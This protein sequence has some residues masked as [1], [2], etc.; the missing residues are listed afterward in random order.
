MRI[1]FWGNFGIDNFGNECTLA[2]I[3]YNM[4]QRIPDAEFVCISVVPEDTARRHRIET[5]PMWSSESDESGSRLMQPIRR[6][7]KPVA[8]WARALRQA[9]GL[10]AVMVPGTGVLNDINEGSLGLPYNLFRWVL[11]TRSHG[12]RVFFVSVG[13]DSVTRLLPRLLIRCALGLARRCSFR[14]RQSLQRIRALGFQGAGEVFPDLAFSLPEYVPSTPLLPSRGKAVAVGIYN[15]RDQGRHGGVRQAYHDYVDQIS[16]LVLWLIEHRYTARLVIGDISG[17]M[18]VREDVRARLRARGFDLAHP[19]YTDEPATSYEQIMD[20]LASVDFVIAS[21]FHN[22]VLALFLG[23]PVISLSYEAKIDAVMLDMGLGEYC[24]PLDRLDFDRLIGQ[25]LQLE[26]E[27]P[28]LR[29]AIAERARLNRE[30]LERQ[31]DLLVADLGV[32]PAGHAQQRP[33][34]AELRASG[35]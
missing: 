23:R 3:F 35:R 1:A 4:R 20:Q 32:S 11:A 10:T 15:Y 5:I 19:A 2:A 14:D 31:Y 16:S 21:R 24:Q 6:T 17:D 8:E 25:F 18:G 26:R 12:G 7:V 28:Q 22:I 13:V 34:G 29:S 33:S 30:K 9:R 27:A